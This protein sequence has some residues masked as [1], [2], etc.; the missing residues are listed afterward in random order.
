LTLTNAFLTV[1]AGAQLSVQGDLSVGGGSTLALV[2]GSPSAGAPLTVTGCL[3]LNG[4]LQIHLNFSLRAQGGSSF[5][6]PIASGSGCATT[7]GGFKQV[8]VTTN[9]R[10]DSV[11]S[12]QLEKQ[13]ILQA[14]VAFQNDCSATSPLPGRWA[15]IGI[16][17][18][19][20][21]YRTAQNGWW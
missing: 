10:C 5:T 7:L 16:A 18:I 14:V 11:T 3:I 8:T 6:V 19:S 9:D 12:T 1:P 15:A 13:S 20:L 21:S 17:F 4:T 2:I